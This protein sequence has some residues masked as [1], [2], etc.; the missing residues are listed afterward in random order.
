M[1]NNSNKNSPTMYGYVNDF[2]LF[3]YRKFNIK[4]KEQ[5]YK[6]ITML[7]NKSLDTQINIFWGLLNPKERNEFISIYNFL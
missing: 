1:S 6:C 3:F 4:T 5:V 7:H 2:F